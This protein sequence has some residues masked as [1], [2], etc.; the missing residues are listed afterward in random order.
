MKKCSEESRNFYHKNLHS[1]DFQQFHENFE[2]Y[3]FEAI[4]HIKGTQNVHDYNEFH[5]WGTL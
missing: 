5:F 4:R 2:P 1:C 3:M